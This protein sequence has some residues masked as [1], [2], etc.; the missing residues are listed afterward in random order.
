M[1]RST[2]AGNAL[3]QMILSEAGSQSPTTRRLYTPIDVTISSALDKLL[4]LQVID[5]GFKVLSIEVVFIVCIAYL[6][7][8]P[9]TNKLKYEKPRKKRLPREIDKKWLKRKYC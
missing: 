4:H 5:D 3:M 8:W 6:F 1:V 2:S 9:S 7:N